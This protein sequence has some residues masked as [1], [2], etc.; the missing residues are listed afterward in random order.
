MKVAL[1]SSGNS[2]L[3]GSSITFLASVTSAQGFLPGKTDNVVFKD[4]AKSLGVMRL[5]QG[6]ADLTLSGLS[7]GTHAITAVYSGNENYAASV[8]PVLTQV[9]K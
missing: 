2:L 4:G 5:N 9:V 7:V 3:Y 8:S 1:T 6:L